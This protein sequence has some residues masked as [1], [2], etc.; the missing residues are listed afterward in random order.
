MAAS[1]STLFNRCLSCPS[2]SAIP[3]CFL[4]NYYSATA[5]AAAATDINGKQQQWAHP[6]FHKSSTNPRWSLVSEHGKGRFPFLTVSMAPERLSD[7]ACGQNIDTKITLS[8]WV[9]A[10]PLGKRQRE[11]WVAIIDA[12]MGDGV[13]IELLG[14]TER[15]RFKG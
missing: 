1:Y 12:C 10:T 7:C 11:N 8:P 9:I 6:S 15:S 3:S 14:N 13:V 4:T 5:A 2:T